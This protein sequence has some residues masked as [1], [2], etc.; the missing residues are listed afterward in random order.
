MWS[1]DIHTS[2][3]EKFTTGVGLS[4]AVGR[5]CFASSYNPYRMDNYYTLR[6][7]ARYQVNEH[8]TLHL[9]VENLTNQKYVTE[10]AYT[11]YDPAAYAQSIICAGTAAHAGCDITF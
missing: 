3:T 4:A 11:V 1:A 8:L 10:S 6:W 7:Y 5:T 2:P 9:R